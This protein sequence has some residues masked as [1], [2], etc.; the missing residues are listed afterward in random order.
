MRKRVIKWILVISA[1]C[2]I[3]IGVEVLLLYNHTSTL[4]STV[5]RLQAHAP[6]IEA[7]GEH[8]TYK[9]TVDLKEAKPTKFTQGEGAYKDQ[10]YFYPGRPNSPA[11]IFI[12]K[13]G[14]EYYR[15]MRSTII[16]F[17]GV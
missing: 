15:Y 2:V 10:M 6:K 17:H 13:Q 1:I 8:W 12:K 9:D 4:Y 3:Y 5:K 16:F 11:N 14:T 7:Y